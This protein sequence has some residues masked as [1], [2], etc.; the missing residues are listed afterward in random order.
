LAHLEPLGPI[1]S[2][3]P[4]VVVGEAIPAQQ[5]HQP[6]VTPTPAHGGMPPRVASPSTLPMSSRCLTEDLTVATYGNH[7]TEDHQGG[8]K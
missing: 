7:G 8:T 5:H 2:V 3:D 6:P 1:E 4:L